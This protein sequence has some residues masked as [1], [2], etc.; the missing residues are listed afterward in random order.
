MSKEIEYKRAYKIINEALPGNMFCFENGGDIDTLNAIKHTIENAPKFIEEEWLTWWY[1]NKNS[2]AVICAGLESRK[3]PK[4][5]TKKIVNNLNMIKTGKYE[6]NI[7]SKE[8]Y[9]D[10]QTISFLLRNE[11]YKEDF[12]KIYGLVHSDIFNIASFSYSNVKKQASVVNEKVMNMFAEACIKSYATDSM[13][14]PFGQYPELVMYVRDENFIREI[15]E[16]DQMKAGRKITENQK[17]IIRACIVSNTYIS[18]DLRNEVFDMGCDWSQIREFTDK[19]IEENYL[20]AADTYTE[21][22]KSGGFTSIAEQQAGFFLTRMLDS[23]KMPEAFEVDLANRIIEHNEKGYSHMA[24]TLFENTKSKKVFELAEKFKGSS[25]ISIYD[26][27]NIPEEILQKRIETL[28]NKMVKNDSKGKKTPDVWYSYISNYSK[29]ITLTEEQ[30]KYFFNTAN[31]EVLVSFLL[32]DKTPSN[33]INYFLENIYKKENESKFS[34][35]VPATA[36]I[37]KYIRENNIPK[38][39][40]DYFLEFLRRKSYE[41]S[42]LKIN[43]MNGKCLALYEK[44]TTNFMEFLNKKIKEK[45]L[46]REWYHKKDKILLKEIQSMINKRFKIELEK[47]KYYETKSTKNLSNQAVEEIRW[48]LHHKFTDKKNQD[49]HREFLILEECME[50]VN[51]IYP[52]FTKRKEQEKEEFQKWLSE[53]EI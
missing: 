33:I 29:K 31:N 45:S 2:F 12:D 38:D 51:I 8:K 53:K 37:I 26:H 48:E 39:L 43:D 18:D 11:M 20:S 52:E 28:F 49:P 50:D 14:S 47:K 34:A 27:P 35:I 17:E 23:Q 30:Y 25:K 6:R 44:S 1:E 5:V 22:I 42:E 4:S 19:I 16:D 3:V 32:S 10:N 15:L 46:N 36:E 7:W 9:K 13:Y 41:Y 21:S 24:E 40:K